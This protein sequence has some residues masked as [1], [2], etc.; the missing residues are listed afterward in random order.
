MELLDHLDD[1]W[2]ALSR[3]WPS[4]RIKF[5]WMLHLLRLRRRATGVF[6][7]GDYRP[8]AVTGPD[9]DHVIAYARVHK[10]KA[11][12]IIALRHFMEL[13]DGGRSWPKLDAIDAQ[14]RLD[15]SCFRIDTVAQSTIEIG[16]ML[17]H[18]PAIVLFGELEPSATRPSTAHRRPEPA[19]QT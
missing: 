5:A 14:V 9:R 2:E 17:N 13:T 7:L 12:L 4:G 8:L 6:T 15:E 10:H 11:A 3:D 18:V 16:A 1:D 19:R